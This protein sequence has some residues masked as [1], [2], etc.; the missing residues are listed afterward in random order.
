MYTLVIAVQVNTALV[1]FGHSLTLLICPTSLYPT[2]SDPIYL[3]KSRPPRFFQLPTRIPPATLGAPTLLSHPNPQRHQY[4]VASAFPSTAFVAAAMGAVLGRPGMPLAVLAALFSN[5]GNTPRL[6]P[7]QYSLASYQSSFWPTLPP[8]PAHSFGASQ[9]NATSQEVMAATSGADVIGGNITWVFSP[10]ASFLMQFALFF[11]ARL[12]PNFP[13]VAYT[14]R[15]YLLVALVTLA[16]QFF[17]S[18]IML[19]VQD[20]AVQLL[21]AIGIAVWLLRRDWL[22]ARIIIQYK[23]DEAKANNALTTLLRDNQ[24]L[25]RQN[26]ALQAQCLEFAE[27]KNNSE[28]QITENSKQIGALK[29]SLKAECK[30]HSITRN[31]LRAWEARR[32]ETDDKIKL[33][34]IATG[35]LEA[36][37]K[38]K[39]A[40]LDEIDALRKEHIRAERT[41]N[42]AKQLERAAEALDR[43]NSATIQSAQQREL[44]DEVGELSKRLTAA[45]EDEKQA[46]QKVVDLQGKQDAGTQ[47]DVG[48]SLEP[49]LASAT[50]T[51]FEPSESASDKP[52][53]MLDALINPESSRPTPSMREPPAVLEEPTSLLPSSP[54]R[55]R[56]RSEDQ[57]STTSALHS[58]G[59]LPNAAQPNTD[60]ISPQAA[61]LLEFFKA[62]PAPELPPISTT[63]PD[64]PPTSSNGNLD[65]VL[66]SMKHAV[67]PLPAEG[68]S[69]DEVLPM[70]LALSTSKALLK[71]SAYP[72]SS[73]RKAVLKSAQS[74]ADAQ[75]LISASSYAGPT[76]SSTTGSNTASAEHDASSGSPEQSEASTR[77]RPYS[78][79]TVGEVVAQDSS[80]SAVAPPST[81]INPS[82]PSN[83]TPASTSKLSSGIP[84]LFIRSEQPTHMSGP[85]APPLCFYRPHMKP[86]TR[87]GVVKSKGQTFPCDRK[88]CVGDPSNYDQSTGK[89]I[90]SEDLEASLYGGSSKETESAREFTAWSLKLCYEC[91]VEEVPPSVVAE[92]ADE[93]DEHQADEDAKE[94]GDSGEGATREQKEKP[95]M[96]QVVEDQDVDDDFD[97]DVYGQKS[98]TGYDEA[99]EEQDTKGGEQKTED[100]DAGDELERLLQEE[101]DTQHAE[102]A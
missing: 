85:I 102:D 54:T 76:S 3:P 45:K 39:R 25:M 68:K 87:K 96:S 56:E 83:T 36:L 1:S 59:P 9:H 79:Q 18:P 58:P 75:L 19:L 4:K 73:L 91:Y 13:L 98:E 71:T 12:A 44:V 67:Q 78:K 34:E 43:A 6:D 60:S 84:G 14:G 72:G 66:P 26:E 100:H 46:T 5:Y 17:P 90:K 80:P 38:K 57:L 53:T 92:E 24:A 40:L 2:S 48:A 21:F 62:N 88:D 32:V 33:A 8:A 31:A 86:V 49:T 51:T 70:H 63:D 16:I 95:D 15:S 10:H 29:G 22:A 77:A 27:A 55:E 52:R 11:L 64:T 99:C 47:R 50:S 28:R 7:P 82:P 93:A 65:A 89:L 97:E 81:R 61:K 35:S 37:R 41:A 94:T 30:K 101:F 23:R 20:G 42:T 74:A 69:A